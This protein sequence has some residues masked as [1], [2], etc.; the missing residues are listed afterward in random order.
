MPDSEKNKFSPGKVYTLPGMVTYGTEAVVSRA[1]IQKD[2]GNV[3]L[4]AFDANQSISE[5][6]A[7]YDAMVYVIEGSL[8]ITIDGAPGRLSAGDV[9]IMPAGK[10]HALSADERS[11][12][13]LVM[14]RQ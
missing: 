8:V 14:I 12:M 7:P 5:H 11:K 2:A 6:T 3:T 1:L 10:P 4:F 13:L 9:M